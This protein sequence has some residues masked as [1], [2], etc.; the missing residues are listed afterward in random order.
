[1]L[2]NVGGNG[3]AWASQRTLY[4]SKARPNTALQRTPLRG[5]QDRAILKAGYGSNEFAI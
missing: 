5:E 3:S 2:V 1:M 4:Y